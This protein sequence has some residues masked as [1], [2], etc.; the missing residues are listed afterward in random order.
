MMVGHPRHNQPDVVA[1][2]I[3]AVRERGMYPNAPQ[4]E[5]PPASQEPISASELRRQ[6]E[7]LYNE[8][9][10]CEALVELRGFARDQA[11][12]LLAAIHNLDVRRKALIED[13]RH[14]LQL[15]DWGLERS[16]TSSSM[17]VARFREHRRVS[18]ELADECRKLLFEILWRDMGGPGG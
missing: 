11:P 15:L 2:G 14:T 16:G 1:R 4:H 3:H 9:Q 12:I 10:H 18:M 17:A 13:V 8:I 5:W 7:C 6:L